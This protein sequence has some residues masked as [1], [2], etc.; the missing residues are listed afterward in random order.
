MGPP[1]APPWKKEK[2]PNPMEIK[3]DKLKSTLAKLQPVWEKY[4]PGLFMKQML[5][6]GGEVNKLTPAMVG[7]FIAS[8]ES[9]RIFVVLD[10]MDD[11]LGKTASMASQALDMTKRMR[12]EMIAYV[13]RVRQCLKGQSFPP[14]WR[15]Y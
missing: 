7:E 9:G 12:N 13:E 8:G 2:R 6:T 10:G 11:L 15:C 4:D 3:L 1:E 5:Q 14:A